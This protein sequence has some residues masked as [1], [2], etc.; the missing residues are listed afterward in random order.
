MW[1]YVGAPKNESIPEF[2]VLVNGKE[3]A[4]QEIQFTF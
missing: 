1:S 2:Q 3:L 4:A